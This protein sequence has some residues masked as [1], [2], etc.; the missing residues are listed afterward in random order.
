MPH[1]SLVII[2]SGSG[3]VVVPGDRA[4]GIWSLGDASSPYPLK[5]VAN[6]DRPLPA[7][8]RC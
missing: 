3:N 7:R 8:S 1:F 5:H 4:A 6:A 2:G